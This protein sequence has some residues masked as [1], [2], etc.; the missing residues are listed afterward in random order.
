LERFHNA[1]P[2]IVGVFHKEIKDEIDLSRSLI[3]PFGRLRRFFDRPGNQLYREA[4]AFL[5]QSTVKDR[6]TQS[7]LQIRDRNYPIR[8][9]NEAHDSL[10]YL[11]P[12]G[13]YIDICKELKPI[14]EQPI[15]FTTCSIKR[16]LLT[17]PCD[18]E[19]G[20]NYK[21][22]HKLKF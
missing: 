16:G 1:S 22:L 10:T 17:I 18:F 3:N 19:V 15:D 7:A 11:M 4:F 13:E 5:P 6:L 14:M 12:I 2:N 8:L 20:E 21:D 9:V